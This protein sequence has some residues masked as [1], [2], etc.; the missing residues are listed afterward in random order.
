LLSQDILVLQEGGLK[1]L[2]TRYLMGFEQ[3]ET[4][5]YK[6]DMPNFFATGGQQEWRR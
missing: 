3:F 1:N 2:A 4:R 5:T 6:P